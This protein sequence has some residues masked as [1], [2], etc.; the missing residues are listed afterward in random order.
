MTAEER[1]GLIKDG[2]DSGSWADL[3]SGGGAFTLAL[4]EMLGP[5]SRIYSVDSSRSALQRQR[6]T[7]A[8][9]FPSLP[10]EYINRNYNDELEFPPLDGI[11]M[12][13]SLHYQKDKPAL[14]NKIRSYLKPGGRFLLVEY[15]ISRGNPWVPY[16]LP[17]PEWQTL[18]AACGFISTRLLGTAPSRYHHEVYAALSRVEA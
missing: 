7:M 6:R 5:G 11:L 18:S 8:A 17:Y 14:L 15:N 2:V 3:G 9:A 13:N 16:P 12:A 4:A 10:V 1:F